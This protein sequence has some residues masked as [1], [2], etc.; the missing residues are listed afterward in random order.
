MFTEIFL[1]LLFVALIISVIIYTNKPK[2]SKPIR[3]HGKFK[4]GWKKNIL[5]TN[6]C[7]P[8]EALCNKEQSKNECENGLG[9]WNE[10]QGGC[11]FYFNLIG[12]NPKKEKMPT[13]YSKCHSVI[14][15]AVCDWK[16]LNNNCVAKIDEKCDIR[17]VKEEC[18]GVK[19]AVVADVA[20]CSKVMTDEDKELCKWAPMDPITRRS[21]LENKELCND[22][23]IQEKTCKK[24]RGKLQDD[25]SCY[26]NLTYT[27]LP[28]EKNEECESGLCESKV[29]T[30]NL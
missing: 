9:V 3:C 5:E 8:S 21:V 18:K 22:K 11:S 6:F 15:D 4:C 26:F 2:E 10:S 25:S 20:T 27:G 7:L 29:C 12:L 17:K 16:I 23:A 1:L 24:L 28:C 14:E 30:N 19:L 13:K